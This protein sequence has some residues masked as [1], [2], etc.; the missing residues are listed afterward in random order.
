MCVWQFDAVGDI[1]LC[2]GGFW[3]WMLPVIDGAVG[4][5]CRG[6]ECE[7]EANELRF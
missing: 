5:K 7:Y 2:A 3:C 4:V 6:C 1:R